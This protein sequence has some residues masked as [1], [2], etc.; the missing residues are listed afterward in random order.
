MKALWK[1]LLGLVLTT[2]TGV[3]AQWG[4]AATEENDDIYY[5]SSDRVYEENKI[6]FNYEVK[7]YVSN[8]VKVMRLFLQKCSKI[9][10]AQIEE[11]L[12]SFSTTMDPIKLLGMIEDY[13]H[14]HGGAL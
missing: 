13:F 10:R 11:K 6:I 1:I 9:L 12:N 3:F 5:N 8:C 14:M 4:G 7:E 2:P